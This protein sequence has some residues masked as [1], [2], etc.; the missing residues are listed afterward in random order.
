MRTALIPLLFALSV[1]GC[2]KKSAPTASADAP[3]PAPASATI[4]VSMPGGGNAKAFA[5]NLID[6]DITNWKPTGSGSSVQFI[7]KTLDFKSD[8]TW[9]ADAS[10][11][12][13]FEEIPC[14]E[15][16]TWAI[17][18]AESAQI[19]TITWTLAKTNC[20]MR[21]AGEESRGQVTMGKGTGFAVAFR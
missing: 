8:G 9:A 1:T 7:Y 2:G 14:A 17:A 6:L 20:A 11:E 16:G 10:V 5:K 19:G 12:A 18:D 3:A 21:E 4:S 13:N 15:S